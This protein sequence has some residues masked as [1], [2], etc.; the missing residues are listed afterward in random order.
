MQ[1]QRHSKTLILSIVLSFFFQLSFGQNPCVPNPCMNFGVCAQVNFTY[2]CGCTEYWIGSNCT[3]AF[4]VTLVAPNAPVVCK[5]GVNVPL[6]DAIQA[7]GFSGGWYNLPASG[8]SDMTI[9]FTIT[10]G[11][12]TLGTTG[13]TFG[14]N[15]NGS[16]NFTATGQAEFVT[17]NGSTVV[18]PLVDGALNIAL[19]DATFTPTP[20]LFGVNAASITF[21][22]VYGPWTSQ[23]PASITFDINN[24]ATGTDT[25]TECDSLVWI[26]GNTYYANNNSATFNIV[27]GAANLCDSLVTLDLTIINSATETDTRTECDSLVWI[28]GNTYYA[29]N[30]SAT[31]NIVG[32]AAN[33]CDSLVTLDLTIK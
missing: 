30:N 15:G 24:S 25:R 2:T 31:F 21:T 23:T 5:N 33:L 20:N 26:D 18:N 16:S 13:V 4:P 14:G 6:D 9:T 32:G 12:L 10:G 28:D 29:N 27:G 19:D 3:I 17:Y 1:K 7:S 8:P 22:A 11:T